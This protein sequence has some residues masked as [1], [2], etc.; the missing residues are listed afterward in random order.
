MN[1]LPRPKPLVVVILDGWGVSAHKTGNAI[2]AAE[3][4]T[5]E[6]FAQHFPTA[7]VAAS[8]M[9]VGLPWGEVGN[10][11]TGHRNIGAG[12]VQ[13]QVLPLIDKAIEKGTFF[14]NPALVEVIK[15]TQKNNTALHLMGLISTGGVHAHLKHLGA[16]L[17]LVAQLAPKLKTYIHAFTDGRDTPPQ[18]AEKFLDEIEKLRQEYGVGVVA[19]VTGR[20]YAMDRN[21]NWERTEATFKMLTGGER[22][23][24]APSAKAAVRRAYRQNLYDEKIPPTAITQGGEPMATMK[25]G[26]GAIFFNFRPDRA[27]QLTKLMA[28]VEGLNLVTMAQYDANLPIPSAFVEEKAEY[29]LARLISEAGL[30]QLHIAETEKYAHITYY[31]NVGHE[32]PFPQEEHLLIKSSA[33]QD[34]ALE[35]KMAAETIT[36]RLLAEV[37]Q[38]KFDVYFVNYANPDMLGHTGNFEA[39][40]I[41]CAWVDKMLGLVYEEVVRAVGGTLLVTADHGNAE[42]MINPQSGEIVTDHSTNPVPLHLVHPQLARRSR[43]SAQELATIMEAP[44]GVLADVAPTI[45]EILQIEAPRAMTGVSLLSSLR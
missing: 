17:K 12:A 3:T 25:P 2:L 9:E 45:L 33:T 14:S 21:E 4:P 34:F 27:R 38:K 7:I 44:I 10:S 6:M 22:A 19:S 35:P 29:P 42:E 24:G 39:A 1:R 16:L 41:G 40:K 13:Y 37:N 43:R 20:L 18:S 11:E 30:K 32:Q 23:A 5:M 36:E 31:L 28:Q 15:K 26:D 8:G